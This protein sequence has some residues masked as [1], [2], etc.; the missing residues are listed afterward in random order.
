[1]R[2]NEHWFLTL[3]GAGDVSKY[4]SPLPNASAIFFLAA[5]L[6]LQR[7]RTGAA[8]SVSAP[9]VESNARTFL[10]RAISSSME[11]SISGKLNENLTP[12]IGRKAGVA[13]CDPLLLPSDKKKHYAK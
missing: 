3:G 4:K 5:A 8:P 10:S 2:L 7:L 1:V 11:A 13:H 6:S 12:R 9:F